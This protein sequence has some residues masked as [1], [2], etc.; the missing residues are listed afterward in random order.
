MELW[1][2]RSD[3][4]ARSIATMLEEHAVFSCMLGPFRSKYQLSLL[5]KIETEAPVAVFAG[6]SSGS[7]EIILW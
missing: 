4:Q 5:A 6:A 7:L 2:H 1:P 3:W